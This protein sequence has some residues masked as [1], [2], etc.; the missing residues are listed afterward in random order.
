MSIA[1][2]SRSPSYAF[3]SCEGS[4]SGRPHVTSIF[5][6]GH[7]GDERDQTRTPPPWTL[8]PVFAGAGQAGAVRVERHRVHRAGVVCEGG[9]DLAAGGW[10]PDPHRPIC[11]GSGQAGAVRVE[12]HRVHRVGEVCE[13]GAD[14]EY[15]GWI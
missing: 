7:Q 12:R 6:C 15:G 3:D 8:T 4:R 14:L 13:G 2:T 10:I 5:P 11:A 9:A 1:A